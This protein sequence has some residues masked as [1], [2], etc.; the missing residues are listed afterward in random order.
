MC[1]LHCSYERHEARRAGYLL[2]MMQNKHW[3]VYKQSR[4][5]QHSGSAVH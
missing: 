1:T 4:W 5:S 3:G 2:C